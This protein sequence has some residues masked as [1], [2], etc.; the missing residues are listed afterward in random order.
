MLKECFLFFQI[1]I[2]SL[3]TLEDECT[4]CESPI[5]TSQKQVTTECGHVFH[6]ECVVERLAK[7]KKNDCRTCMKP[8]ALADA[9]EKAE[10]NAPFSS[11]QTKYATYVSSCISFS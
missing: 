8:Y 2:M 9:I 1:E 7:K 5:E 3:I 10:T 6:Y 4:I 11:N